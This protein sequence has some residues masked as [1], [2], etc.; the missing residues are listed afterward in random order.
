MAAVSLSRS[1][2]TRENV[3]NF[4]VF[5]I[6]AAKPPI[7]TP[8]KSLDSGQN[9]RALPV[10]SGFK[11]LRAAALLELQIEQNDISRIKII[12]AASSRKIS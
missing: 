11:Q 10:F 12:L 3:V 2:A 4:A 9:R 1:T 7:T 5:G 6:L 8:A